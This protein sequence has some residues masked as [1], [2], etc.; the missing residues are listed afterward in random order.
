M[1]GDKPDDDGKVVRLPTKKAQPSLEDVLDINATRYQRSKK[2]RPTKWPSA[3]VASGA[4]SRSTRSLSRR[5]R[6]LWD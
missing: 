5:G 3:I 1:S 6:C 4:K 2:K